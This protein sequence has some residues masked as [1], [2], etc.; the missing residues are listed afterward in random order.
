MVVLQ[1]KDIFNKSINNLFNQEVK[2]DRLNRVKWIKTLK[3]YV[4][5]EKL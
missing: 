5:K 4:K 3:E 1:L 2:S